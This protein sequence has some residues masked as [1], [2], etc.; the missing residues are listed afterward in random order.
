MSIT[1]R[2]PF[3][4]NHPVTFPFG[5]RP[6]E[7]SI[8][9]KFRK[10]G[11]IGH[12]GTD[13]MVAT[14]T[15]I[16][17]CDDGQVSQ[18]G[19]NGDFGISVTIQHSWGESIY[20]HLS[21]AKVTTGQNLKKGELVGLS[22]ESGVVTSPHLHFGIK[23]KNPELDNGYLGFID[24]TPFIKY[25]Q[26]PAKLDKVTQ[27]EIDNKKTETAVDEIARNLAE[28]ELKNPNN[29]TPGVK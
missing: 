2:Q 23:P 28:T 4:G 22:G 29:N 5:V 3:E 18:S 9:E 26:D 7:T 11:L 16:L 12:H 10:W 21:E 19:V 17:A 27:Y 20:G 14:S 24:P 15:P 25:S 1:I 6:T 13:Y 8:Q